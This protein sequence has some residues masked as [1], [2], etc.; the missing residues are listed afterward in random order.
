MSTPKGR[1]ALRSAL[2]WEK[3]NF[4]Y[5]ESGYFEAN[6]YKV[7]ITVDAAGRALVNAELAHYSSG[8]E[9][10]HCPGC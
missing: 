8:S 9:A 6:G 1:Q 2:T 10:A 7:A 4:S 3:K 5:A